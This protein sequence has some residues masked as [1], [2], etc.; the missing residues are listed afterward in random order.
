MN[1]KINKLHER[2]LRIAN[3]DFSTSFATLLEIDKCVTMH[4]KNVQLTLAEMRKTINHPSPCIMD[5]KFLQTNF[6]YQA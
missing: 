2:P 5:E 4:Q 6:T 3:R 1:S